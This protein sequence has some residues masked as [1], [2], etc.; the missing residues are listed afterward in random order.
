MAAPQ[1]PQ[2]PVSTVPDEL[3]IQLALTP[4]QINS[5]VVLRERYGQQTAGLRVR[6]EEIRAE[7][8]SANSKWKKPGLRGEAP[9]NA[10][11]ES[12]LQRIR[13]ADEE[14]RAAV[15]GL[16][17]EQQQ[18]RLEQL[19]QAAALQRV[20]EQAQCFALLTKTPPDEPAAC[21]EY[22]REP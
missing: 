21:A 3:R 17:V 1:R 18:A 5:I 7:Q 15:R 6:L 19:E 13:S 12:L 14:H 4:A 2:P 10:E 11:L 16:L 20:V 22:Q 8:R 9:V